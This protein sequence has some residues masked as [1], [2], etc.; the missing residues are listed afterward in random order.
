MNNI[1]I[2]LPQN[3]AQIQDLYQNF[4][5][6]INLN[7][8]FAGI[9]LLQESNKDMT[10]K[11]EEEIKYEKVPYPTEGL[12]DTKVIPIEPK[13]IGIDITKPTQK[14]EPVKEDPEKIKAE[15]NAELSKRLNEPF[16]REKILRPYE[17]ED[18]EEKKIRDEKKKIEF[19]ET[20]KRL[21]KGFSFLQK[22]NMENSDI[23]NGDIYVNLSNSEG[24]QIPMNNIDR[25][26]KAD[27]AEHPSNPGVGIYKLI[28][29]K[30][31]F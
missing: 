4:F 12:V 17:L 29:L 22:Q 31:N 23:S 28:N 21:A 6:K 2:S 30:E 27:L 1:V 9:S 11:T 24:N 20:Q 16:P 8:T 3:S 13:T 18:M 19:E 5:K 25:L 15:I 10:K 14:I 7:N 26:V